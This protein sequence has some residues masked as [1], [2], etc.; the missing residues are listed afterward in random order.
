MNRPS[1]VRV[2]FTEICL[3]FVENKMTMD[4]VNVR[5]G[6]DTGK[7]VDSASKLATPDLEKFSRQI[8]LLLAQRREEAASKKEKSLLA[9]IKRPL[10]SEEE[11]KKYKSLKRKQQSHT[12]SNTENEE[13]LALIYLKEQRGAER[14]E[15]MI[16]LSELRGIHFDE[17][18][19]QL[20]MAV[21]FPENA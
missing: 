1:P 5:A 9:K 21:P 13:L 2:V 7:L 8:I 16:E 17:L 14:L 12:L 19:E 4:T 11:Q 6:T 3:S 10:L 20:G 18:L 15:H